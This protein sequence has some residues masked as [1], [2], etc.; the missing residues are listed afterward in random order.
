M[1]QLTSFPRSVV[2]KTATHYNKSFHAK[3]FTLFASSESEVN[4]LAKYAP[5]RYAYCYA[6]MRN[7]E[8]QWFLDPKGIQKIRNWILKGSRQGTHHIDKLHRVWE[9]DWKKFMSNCSRLLTVKLD[10]LNDRDLLKEFSL[11]YTQYLRAGSVAYIADAF[12]STGTT[13]WLE[14]MIQAELSTQGIRKNRIETVRLL[15]MPTHLSFTLEEESDLYALAEMF[16]TRYKTLPKF[17]IISKKYPQIFKKLIHHERA[18]HWVRNNYFNVEY[19][20]A[21]KVY[22]RITQLIIHARSKNISLHDERQKKIQ[23]IASYRQERGRLLRALPLSKP[24]KNVLEIARLFAKWKDIRKSGVYMGMHHFGRFLQ[25]IGRRKGLTAY[26]L[27]HLV[28]HEIIELFAQPQEMRKRVATR[29]KQAFFAVTPRGYYIANTRESRPYF[30]YFSVGTSTTVTHLRGVCASAGTATGVVRVVLKTHEMS[31]F[32]KGEILVANQTTPDFVPI[33]KKAAA[34]VTEQ[35]GVTSH[36]AV[37]S[38][39]LKK[40]CIIGTKVATHVFRT[41]DCVEVDADKGIIKKII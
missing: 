22:R 14:D 9:S 7:D 13:D 24:M 6:F 5:V 30:S 15:T 40:P 11:L 10:A 26:E 29:K 38:R 23:E 3:I 36:A 2:A 18:Y 34:I 16:D 25:E 33:L 8:G 41:G 35:G 1:K 39:E 12:M 37:V 19:L 32:K 31:A 17:E 4:T 27:S 21:Q 20:S 28:F